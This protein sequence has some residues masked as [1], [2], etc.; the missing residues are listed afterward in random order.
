MSA[1]SAFQI[2]CHEDAFGLERRYRLCDIA[3][4]EADKY[5]ICRVIARPFVGNAPANF[6]PGS[7]HTR[8]HVP[9]LVY[10]E[11]IGSGSLGVRD[12][13]ADNG[14]SLASWFGLSQFPHQHCLRLAEINPASLF[15]LQHSHCLR[16][17]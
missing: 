7:D 10:G 4:E 6:E 16:S 5:H 2:A 14:Q 1:D 11:Q 8:E 15:H 12:S 9:V 3:R 13:F 17:L